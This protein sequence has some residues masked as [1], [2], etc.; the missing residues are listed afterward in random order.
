MAFPAIGVPAGFV[1]AAGVCFGTASGSTAVDV[2]N[3]LPVGERPFR[4]A[5]AIVPG[6][7]QAPQR[8]LAITCTA[9][10]AVRLKLADDSELAIPVSTGLT[11]LPFQVK[12]VVPAGTTAAATYANLL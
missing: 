6:V 1:P 9:G 3:P 11:V 7:D 8:G 12:T 10:G 2:D 5:V 4:G